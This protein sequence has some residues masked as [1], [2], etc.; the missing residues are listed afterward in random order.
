MY[1]QFE[2]VGV[3]SPFAI[4]IILITSLICAATDKRIR[5]TTSGCPRGQLYP[6]ARQWR[7]WSNRYT[8]IYGASYLISKKSVLSR[9]RTVGTCC[10]QQQTQQQ[11]ARSVKCVVARTAVSEK[12]NGFCYQHFLF[13]LSWQL[14][15]IRFNYFW[16]KFVTYVGLLDWDRLLICLHC[17]RPAQRVQSPNWTS[18]I[19]RVYFWYGICD[20]LKHT[21]PL[22]VF[23]LKWHC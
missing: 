8:Y 14:T 2:I 16:Y 21:Q 17:R 7:M 13:I 15:S 6:Y 11:A 5:A 9:W 19:V 23:G 22:F 4:I 10:W 12:M 3:C 1:S 18:A 20:L